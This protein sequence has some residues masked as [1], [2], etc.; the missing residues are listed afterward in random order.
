VDVV[1]VCIN[2]IYESVIRIKTNYVWIFMI[3]VEEASLHHGTIKKMFIR[4]RL[5]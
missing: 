1:C 4:V 3:E 2:I 5:A